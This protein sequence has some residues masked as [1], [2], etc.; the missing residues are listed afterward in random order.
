MFTRNVLL[1]L[2]YP[3]VVAKQQQTCLKLFDQCEVLNGFHKG[4]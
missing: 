3:Q 2:S 4:K 1:L